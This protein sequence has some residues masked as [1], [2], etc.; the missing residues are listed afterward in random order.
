MSDLPI[1]GTPFYAFY[2]QIDIMT[3]VNMPE[4]YSERLKVFLSSHLLNTDHIC[5]S[6]RDMEQN[7]STFIKYSSFNN[8]VSS[9]EYTAPYELDDW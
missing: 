4:T 8:T 9:S 1:T 6:I 2:R 3:E 7:A 5:F